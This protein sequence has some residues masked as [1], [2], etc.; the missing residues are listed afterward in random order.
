[1]RYT[2]PRFT[3]LLLLSSLRRTDTEPNWVNSKS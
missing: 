2:N 3:Y 1:L